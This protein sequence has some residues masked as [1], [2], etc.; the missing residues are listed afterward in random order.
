[1]ILNHSLD[2]AVDDLAY[3]S[4]DR[5]LHKNIGVLPD[6]HL[7]DSVGKRRVT[8]KIEH[9]VGFATDRLARQSSLF[10]NPTTSTMHEFGKRDQLDVVRIFRRC[11]LGVSAEENEVMVRSQTRHR[12]DE[13]DSQRDPAAEYHR[14][15][16]DENLQ[17]GLIVTVGHDRVI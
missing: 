14:S 15:R 6:G 4:A 13:L 1:M 17:R 8:A 7:G 11:N 9:D 5:R 10:P 12:P 2:Q 16:I 3:G